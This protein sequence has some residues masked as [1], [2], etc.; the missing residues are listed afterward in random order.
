M[1]HVLIALIICAPFFSNF[2]FSQDRAYVKSMIDSLCAPRYH[3]RGYVENGD[4]KAAEFIKRQIE[5]LGIDQPVEFQPFELG[6]NTFDGAMELTVNGVTL[7]PGAD[8]IIDPKSAGKKGEYEAIRFKP[9]WANN[10][11][12]LLSMVADGKFT[13]K[14]VVFDIA[15][16]NTDYATLI[17][18]VYKNPLKAE[19]YIIL[20]DKKLTWSVSRSVVSVP[21]FRVTKSDATKKI[22]IVKLAVDQFFKSKYNAVNV[23][24]TL[25]GTS[26]TIYST[27][28][29]TAHLDHLGR[30]GA[31][32]YIA[33][34]NDN[35]SGS[36][37]LLDLY[38]YYLENRPEQEVIFIWF[39]GEEAGLV[40][41][42]Y[43]VENSLIELSDIQF[44]MNLDLMGDAAQGITAVNGKVFDEHFAKLSSLNMELG[45]LEV[46]KP[47]GPAA[48]SDH[49]PFY[50]MGVPCF[51]VYTMGDYK[52]YHDIN[53]VPANL[54]LTKYDEVFE[55]MVEF[56][57]AGI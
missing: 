40:G 14:V 22:K 9:K 19:A 46:V 34:A 50:E 54:P 36:A 47:R 3:G 30:M 4:S 26:D 12:K 51:F 56:M 2:S 27:M 15:E 37:M 45:L 43:F 57:R 11:E 24:A 41:S 31:D 25:P 55:L 1:K 20:T 35:A 23:M 42:K 38:K 53:D 5:E 16:E 28:V 29:F 48:N 17:G 10:A 13:G 52:H 49:H 7:A 44:L 32:T 18:D 21:I 39:A 33:G 8:Y 6:V